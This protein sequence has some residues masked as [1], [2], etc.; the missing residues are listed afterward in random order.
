MPNWYV[1][2]AL[3]GT[4]SLL[5]D[6]QKY[7]RVFQRF[8]TGTDDLSVDFFRKKVAAVDRHLDVWSSLATEPLPKHIVELGSGWHPIVPVALLLRGA[9]RVTSLDVQH[10]TQTKQVRNVLACFEREVSE[11]PGRW[12]S[13]AS[14]IVARGL[15]SSGEPAELLGAMGIELDTRR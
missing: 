8:V 1:K 14:E 4:M 10:L 5:P 13:D 11:N 2:A 9:E 6:P 12:R 15:A 3:Q 7:N